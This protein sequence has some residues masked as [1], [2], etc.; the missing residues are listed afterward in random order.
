MKW[1]IP[2]LLA[3]ALVPSAPGQSAP[4]ADTTSTKPARASISGIVT[5]E[6][7]SEPV[8]KALIELIAE[9]QTEGGDYTAVSGADGS[10]R[11]EGILSG[12]YRLFV[13]RTGFVERR[14]RH[15]GADGRVLTLSSGQELKDLQIRLQASAVVRGRV[16]DEDGDPMAGAEVSVLHQVYSSGR[17]RWEQTGTDR[18]NDL[19]EYRIANLAAGSYFVSVSPPPDF[20]NLIAASGAESESS[21]PAAEKPAATYQTT[22][23]PG[24][25]DRSQAAPIQLKSGE[26]FPVNFSL[27]PSPTLSIGGAV[28]NLPPGASAVIMLQSRDFNL[29]LNGADVHKDGTFVIRDVAPGSYTITASVEN[30]PPGMMARQ[31]LQIASSNVDD[32]RLAP[33]AGAWLHGRVRLENSA[34]DPKSDLSQFLLNLK[35]AD[36]DDDLLSMSLSGAGFSSLVRVNPDGTFEWKGVPPG[37]YFVQLANSGS[38]GTNWYPRSELVDGRDF[39]GQGIPVSGG[40]VS[41][42]LFLSPNGAV[43]DGLVSDAASGDPGNPGA[44]ADDPGSDLPA[45]ATAASVPATLADAIVVAVPEARWRGQSSRYRATVSD[46]NGR[47]TL[48]GLPPGD[49]SLY[50]WESLDGEAYLNPEFLKACEGQGTALHVGEGD[51]R[52]LRLTAIPSSDSQ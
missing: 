40:A 34:G 26:E 7:D 50:A 32:V 22:F 19:G 43:V 4:A 25:A 36:G 51:H 10:F 24:T 17:G 52:S 14:N 16:T 29:T 41:V 15:S 8:K 42:D 21:I 46:Q 28:V 33:Q 49:Y 48:R 9:N 37:N 30:G 13:E 35:S 12:R 18:T 2:S 38:S 5:R 45:K 31:A 20:R 39:S 44:A 3:V 27:G 11:I 1:F 47:F 6:P 23:Y